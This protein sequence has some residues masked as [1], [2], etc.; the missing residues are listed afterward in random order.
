MSS[1]EQL[2]AL[3]QTDPRPVPPLLAAHW[4]R[5]AAHWNRVAA[6]NPWVSL[7]YDPP[8]DGAGVRMCASRDELRRWL[9][10]GNWSN[11]SAFAVEQ[12]DQV[13]CFIQQGECSDEWLAIK[14]QFV[15]GQ[16]E[17][18][19]FESISWYYILTHREEKFAAYLDDM[20]AATLA[21][22]RSLSYM[23]AA[24]RLTS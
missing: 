7:A 8:F 4:N 20:F 24:G 9:S 12:S 23:G 1:W 18:V 5:V 6:I 10:F 11:G 2:F 19:T 16:W 22:C 17:H 13:L 21:E 14:S 3:P 15:D